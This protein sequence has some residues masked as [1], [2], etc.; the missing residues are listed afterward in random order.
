[1]KSLACGPGFVACTLSQYSSKFPEKRPNGSSGTSPDQRGDERIK[2]EA[3]GVWLSEVQTWGTPDQGRLGLGQDIDAYYT[4]DQV[5]LSLSS[6]LVRGS[7]SQQYQQNTS[8]PTRVMGTLVRECVD[9]VSC[10]AFHTLVLTNNHIL[11]AFGDNRSGQLGLGTNSGA[12]RRARGEGWDCLAHTRT[13]Q[14]YP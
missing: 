9:I 11:F 6:P 1:V 14:M 2:T 7:T 5:S 3:S 13:T 8:Q 10:G 4:V 12:G